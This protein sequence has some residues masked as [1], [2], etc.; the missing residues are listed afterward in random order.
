[1]AE[2]KAADTFS[3]PRGAAADGAD[4]E[5]GR[6][7]AAGTSDG[8][9]GVDGVDGWEGVGEDTG[10]GVALDALNDRAAGAGGA[11]ATG[12]C[13]LGLADGG[14]ATARSTGEAAGEERPESEK[15]EKRLLRLA[16]GGAGGGGVE[17][18]GRWW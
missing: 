16:G 7:E 3:T 12:L 18:S 13:A 8:E 5:W 2:G 1:M 15:A 10:D 14:A 17:A 4:W 9:E 11:A 6:C